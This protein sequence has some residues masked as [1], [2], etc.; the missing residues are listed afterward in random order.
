MKPVANALEI[1]SKF[2]PGLLVGTTKPTMLEMM[3]L[4]DRLERKLPIS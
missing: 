2:Y 1:G 4:V 3:P